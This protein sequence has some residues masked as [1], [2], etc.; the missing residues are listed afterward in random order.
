MT[1]PDDPTRPGRSRRALDHDHAGEAYTASAPSAPTEVRPT[2][3]GEVVSSRSTEAEAKD[4]LA[5]RRAK[6]GDNAA[7]AEL[8]RTN[9][10]AV[11]SLLTALVGNEDLDALCTRVYV[12]AYRGLPV[13]PGTSPRI[14]LLGIADGTARDAIR[15]QGRRHPETGPAGA[16]PSSLPP[17]QRLLLA[18]V[19]AVGLTPREA[20]R[21]VPGGFEHAR[22]Q[23]AAARSDPGVSLPI[24]EPDEHATGFWDDLGRRLLVERASP[25]ASVHPLDRAPTGEAS[26]DLV[27][28]DRRSSS[29]ARGMARRVEQQHPESFPWRK[30][31]VACSLVVAGAAVVAV[32]L[33]VAHHAADRDNALG[34]TAAK[35]LDRLDAALAGDAVVHGTATISSTEADAV[36]TGTFSFTRSDAGSWH[37]TGLDGSLDEGYDVSDATMTRITRRAGAP[38]TAHV[39][40]GL[41]PGPPEATATASGTLGDLLA[42]AIRIVRSGSDGS[43]STRSESTTAKSATTS[44]STTAGQP[45]WVVT[46]TL[47]PQS[48]DGSG[49]GALAGTGAFADVRADEATLVAD[50][51]LALPTRLVLRRRGRVVVS[52]H[53]RNLSISQ[54]PASASYAPTPPAG[55]RASTTDAGFTPTEPGDLTGGTGGS[56]PTPSYLPGGFVFASAGVNRSTD[57]TVLCYRNGSRQLVVTRRPTRAGAA[58]ADPFGRAAPADSDPAKV[59]ISSGAFAGRSGFSASEPIAHVWVRGSTTEAIAAGDP[60][61]DQLTNVLASLR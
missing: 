15:R 54:Q 16:I 43:V 34:E 42:E 60:T 18:A 53:F 13:A 5:L 57:T 41:A 23:L 24:P 26:G 51:S 33:S 36:P 46:S 14:W 50:Q 52:V 12:R 39:R 22:G 38:P 59:T 27:V 37:D 35:T 8:I 11:R 19:E 47:N 45:V 17:D 2:P 7:F 10:G 55:A 49:P 28:T 20:A 48:G 6:R 21:L 30:F 44:A 25:A 29:A 40:R 32:A 1:A 9:D 61:V 56:L 31:I 4:L 58:A 3:A